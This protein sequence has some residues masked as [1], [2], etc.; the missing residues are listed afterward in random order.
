MRLV[1][2][3][4]SIAFASLSALVGLPASP[5]ES[6]GMGGMKMT[7]EMMEGQKRWE[8]ACI[9]GEN[10]KFFEQF[11]GKWDV[12]I[13]MMMGGPGS[14]GM[15]SKGTSECR[16]LAEGRWILR[17][18]K[19]S[20]MGMPLTAWSI[21]GYDNYK[22]KFVCTTVDSMTTVM[23]YGE[24][25]LDQSKKSLLLYGPMDEPITGEHDKP[26]KYAM[27]ILG[28]DKNVWE[29]HDLAIGETNTKVVEFVFTRAK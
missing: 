8:A 6:G 2:V 22:K 28:P 5:Q 11:L 16:W 14:P 18:T 4:G 13:K 3:L 20:L 24:G 12:S 27:R 7:P 29:V 10:H 23:L 19:G 17:E 9:P 25:M 1:F 26:V 15:E 21:L